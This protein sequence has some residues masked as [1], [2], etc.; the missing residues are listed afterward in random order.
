MSVMKFKLI[1]TFFR[2]NGDIFYG[3]IKRKGL[4][5]KPQKHIKG[6]KYGYSAYCGKLL[7]TQLR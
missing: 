1:I 2:L 3:K 4:I 7:R 5:F 6:E